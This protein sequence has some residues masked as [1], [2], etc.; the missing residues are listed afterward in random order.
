VVGLVDGLVEVYTQPADGTYRRVAPGR[1][2][3][4]GGFPDIEIAIDDVL[5]RPSGEARRIDARLAGVAG[6]LD[7]TQ[8]EQRGRDGERMR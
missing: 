1:S 4:S 5:R 3:S 6:V 2:Y 8:R 7:G